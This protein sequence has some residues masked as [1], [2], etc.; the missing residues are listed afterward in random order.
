MKAMEL[1]KQNGA[2]SIL[3]S[4]SKSKALN[5]FTPEQKHSYNMFDE[6]MNY[7]NFVIN[8]Q[9]QQERCWLLY[10]AYMAR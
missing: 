10:P 2:L 1:M 5:L 3:A 7:K 6:A 8:L 9:M 4:M